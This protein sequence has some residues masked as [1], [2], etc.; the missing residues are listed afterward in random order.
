MLNKCSLERKTG[1]QAGNE[2]AINRLKHWFTV[3]AHEIKQ[4]QAV[5]NGL[6]A[7]KS[8]PDSRGPPVVPPALI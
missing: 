4:G 6:A 5:R 3:F 1:A 8:P 7:L 2:Y